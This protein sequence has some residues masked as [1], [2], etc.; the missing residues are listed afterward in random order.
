M[1]AHLGSGAEGKAG[2]RGL[3]HSLD[4]PCLSNQRSRALNR[5][6]A[7][8]PIA[9]GAQYR[10]SRSRDPS[11]KAEAWAGSTAQCCVADAPVIEVVAKEAASLRS[12]NNT[13]IASRWVA[14]APMAVPVVL[15]PAGQPAVIRP[16]GAV[17]FGPSR[18][19]RGYFA[20]PQRKRCRPKAA[21]HQTSM[22]SAWMPDAGSLLRA[23]LTASISSVPMVLSRSMSSLTV[24]RPSTSMHRIS[25][26]SWVPWMRERLCR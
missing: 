21:L 3:G 9:L 10:W 18:P 25:S 24:I 26:I 16:P 15:Q 7:S 23:R 6:S 14:G 20:S 19:A 12:A 1:R 17:V 4:A 13:P 11:T 5:S 8:L 22:V 2:R